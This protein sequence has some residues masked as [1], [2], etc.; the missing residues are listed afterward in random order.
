VV[1][2]GALWFASVGRVPAGV[3]WL[4]E[5]LVPPAAYQ[6]KALKLEQA[7]ARAAQARSASPAPAPPAP[8]QAK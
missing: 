8:A 7:A 6:S 1:T 4:V 3:G 2:A 5:A